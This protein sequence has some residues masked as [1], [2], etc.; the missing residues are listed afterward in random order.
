MLLGGL[1]IISAEALAPVARFVATWN[2]C[3][4]GR[5]IT[6]YPEEDGVQGPPMED[7]ASVCEMLPGKCCLPHVWLAEGLVPENVDSS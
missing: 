1:V 3:F 7:L 2:F 5:E 6:N 4:T